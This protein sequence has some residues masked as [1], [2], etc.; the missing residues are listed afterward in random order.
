MPSTQYAGKCPRADGTT[1][2]ACYFC[3]LWPIKVRGANHD[4][5][6]SDA[7]TNHNALLMGGETFFVGK[8]YDIGRDSTQR[9]GTVLN[10]AARP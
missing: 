10:H 8:C 3:R 1:E 7:L 5:V 2:R 9:L 4:D 6:E